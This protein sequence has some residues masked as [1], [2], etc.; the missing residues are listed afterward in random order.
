MSTNTLLAA[1]MLLRLSSISSQSYFFPYS[2]FQRPHSFCHSKPCT[3]KVQESRTR[4][5]IDFIFSRKAGRD[6]HMYSWRED[7]CEHDG[8]I[9]HVTSQQIIVPIPAGDTGKF[10]N[11]LGAC[12]VV[13]Q[14]A[15]Y[16][17]SVSCRTTWDGAGQSVGVTIEG[18][19][20]WNVQRSAS[21]QLF[22][23]QC[24]FSRVCKFK[25]R[26]VTTHRHQNDCEVFCAARYPGANTL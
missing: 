5:T 22:Q 7:G 2:S 21:N 20:Y 9:S 23:L 3:T 1:H 4:K 6:V 24:S 18:Y 15:A 13:I 16:V 12:T 14:P 17:N 11:P 26:D 10:C 8:K 19:A 25:G